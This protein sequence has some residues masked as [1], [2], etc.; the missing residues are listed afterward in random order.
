MATTKVKAAT[1]EVSP[2]SS[3]KKK[4]SPFLTLPSGQTMELKKV[5]F[6]AFIAAGIVPNSLMGIVQSSIDKGKEVDVS[7]LTKDMSQVNDMMKMMNDVVC[8]C[9]V[10]PEVNPT[11]AEDERSDDL[12][13]VDEID[14][15]DKMFI[16][17]WCTGGTSDVAQFR[18]ESS[19]SL[20]VVQS[21]KDVVLPAKRAPRRR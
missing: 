21:G 1:V 10:N 5:A 3:W 11:P 18:A 13:Y 16:F 15:E 14:D 17:Q 12:L 8:F 2:V 19:D 20:A 6:S 4:A 9:A 7:T